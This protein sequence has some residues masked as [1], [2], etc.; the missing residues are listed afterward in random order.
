MF[1]NGIFMMKANRVNKENSINL[2]HTNKCGAAKQQVIKSIIG[3]K[4]NMATSSMKGMMLPPEAAL[5]TMLASTQ[6][7][8]S[9]EI[10]CSHLETDSMSLATKT[11]VHQSGKLA[12]FSTR[13]SISI[14]AL[15]TTI[16]ANQP[17]KS[18]NTS[19]TMGIGTRFIWQVPHS[20]VFF[21]KVIEK[22]VTD[23]DQFTLI[24]HPQTSFPGNTCNRE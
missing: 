5:K 9:R 10:W 15:P 20:F 14:T 19:V 22:R 11:R 24:R 7:C 1:T 13:F 23:L 8:F 6:P 18:S 2:F 3:Q 17:V 4:S 12:S 16:P 21:L